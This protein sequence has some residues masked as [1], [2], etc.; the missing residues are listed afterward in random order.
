MCRVIRLVSCI[1]GADAISERKLECGNPL[2]ILGVQVTIDASGATY[3]PSEDKVRKWLVKLQ[4]CLDSNCMQPGVAQKLSGALQ[5][6]S[7]NIFRKLGRAMLSPFYMQATHRGSSR[8]GHALRTAVRWWVEVL[9]LGI[10][11]HS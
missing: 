6:A 9:Q 3:K 1:L 2:V 8:M 11:C 7:Q 5:W 10:R 4:T